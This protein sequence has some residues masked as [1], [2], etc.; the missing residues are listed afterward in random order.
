MRAAFCEPGDYPPNV[1]PSDVGL[2][3]YDL[4]PMDAKTSWEFNTD[5]DREGWS[6]GTQM[7]SEV[8]GG[9]LTGEA[10]GRDPVI[11]SPG[12]QV[13]ADRY[14]WLVI[15]MSSSEDDRPQMFW[16]TTLSRH[17]EKNSVRFDVPGDGQMHEIKIDLSQCSQ[18]RGIIV[19]LRFDPTNK[20]G[21]KF[22][23]DYIRLLEK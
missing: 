5:G 11:V 15:R 14:R 2:G 19:S 18:W 1:I 16:A 20:P 4:P 13:E 21:V 10:V 3:P 9:A 7:K 23:I 6:R 8:K 22:A 17:C 12:L